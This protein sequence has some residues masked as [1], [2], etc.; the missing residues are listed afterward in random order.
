MGGVLTDFEIY[1]HAKALIER[2]GG[3]QALAD[4]AARIVEFN[5]FG[6]DSSVVLWQRIR[7]AINILEGAPGPTAT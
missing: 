1:R 7:H 4:A 3:E 5:A 2:Q 6:D